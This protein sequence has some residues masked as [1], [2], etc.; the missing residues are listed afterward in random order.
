R[1]GAARRPAAPATE[2]R[3]RASSSPSPPSEK[4]ASDP[5]LVARWRDAI[6]V[7]L[8]SGGSGNHYVLEEIQDVA[9]GEAHGVLLK[10]V[11][12]E[13]TVRSY[14]AE[15]ARAVLDEKNRWVE[16]RLTGGSLIYSGRSIPFL[17]G[18]YT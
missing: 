4:P 6:N 12:P 11:S 10:K 15:R 18:K 9:G 5:A 2:P 7:L 8:G 17:N 16:I 13:G 14:R 1:G 3:R